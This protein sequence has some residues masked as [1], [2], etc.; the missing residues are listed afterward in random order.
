MHL[1]QPPRQ[2]A[3]R[4]WELNDIRL[5]LS[6]CLQMLCESRSRRNA[7]ALKNIGSQNFCENVLKVPTRACNNHVMD[8]QD[9][10]QIQKPRHR[11]QLV[12]GPQRPASAAVVR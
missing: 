4:T 12:V 7:A 9:A 11:V 2:G 8:V 6:R 3:A 10:L 5:W 1:R